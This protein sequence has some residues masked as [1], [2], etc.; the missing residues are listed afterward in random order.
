VA[1]VGEE[2][3]KAG[4]LIF[5]LLLVALL[6]FAA[7]SGGLNFLSRRNKIVPALRSPAGRAGAPKI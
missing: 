7:L 3:F 5:L 4:T 2:G 6:I 1:C